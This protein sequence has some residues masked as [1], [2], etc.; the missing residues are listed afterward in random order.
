MTDLAYMV[1]EDWARQGTAMLSSSARI[2][3]LLGAGP[4]IFAVTDTRKFNRAHS[5]DLE[6][7]E[8]IVPGRAGH[9]V[10]NIA[11]LTRL[12]DDDRVANVAVVVLHPFGQR[13][14]EALSEVV[15]SEALGR[16]FVMI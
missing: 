1:R 4:V 2:R 10:V 16:V 11:D 6:A 3:E 13:D 15:G 8:Y 12:A 14:N 9:D 5:A 7:A